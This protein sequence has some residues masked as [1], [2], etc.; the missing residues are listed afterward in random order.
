MTLFAVKAR[1]FLKAR[2]G[3]VAMMFAITLVPLMIGAGAGLDYARAMLVRQQMSEALDSA[4]LAVGSTTGLD[5]AAAQALAQKYFDANYTVDKT[6]YG[7]PV[8]QPPVYDAK[9]SISLTATN[10]MPTILIKLAGFTNI[11]LSTTSSVVWG[12]TKLWVSLVLDNSG[13]MCQPDGQP[14]FND[15]NTL[16]KIYQL[17]DATKTMLNSL[18]G[19]AATPGDVRVALVPFNR[20]VNIGTALVGASWIFW[21]FWEQEP[22]DLTYNNTVDLYGPNDNCPFSVGS[23]GYGCVGAGGIPASG[24]IC[25]GSDNGSINKN[26][27]SR[28]YNGCYTSEPT[29]ATQQVF[30]G[31]GAA[32]CSNHQ[33]C[34]CTAASNGNPKHCDA[35]LYKHVWTPNPHSTWT[36]CITDREQDYDISNTAP[37]GSGTSGFPADNP[38][39]SS[40]STECMDGS[41]ASLEYDWSDLT[42]RVDKMQASGSTNQAIGVAHGWEMLTPGGAYG[43]PAL[44]DNTSRYIIL[45]SD[46]LNTQNRWWGDGHTEG[47]PEDDK[48]DD[49]MDKVCSAAKADGVIIF[50]VYVHT[51]TGAAQSDPLQ[52]CASDSSKYYNLTSSSQIAAAFADIT[53]KITNV[54]VSM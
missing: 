1:A 11:P 20:E 46:G 48:I 23:N 31:K 51:G 44:P 29:G 32:T 7:A 41:V 45:F 52:N 3:N 30:N 21:G 38:T 42:T 9:G 26:R 47:T 10:T 40:S 33:N 16:S 50:T 34:T 27:K 24:L 19:V 37:S 22:P 2:R 15:S 39:N 36:G 8:I 43:T 5:Q 14:C 28:Y 12:Q 17:K 18:K 54:R 49:R 4:A 13:S 6:E 25:P 53:K 35:N